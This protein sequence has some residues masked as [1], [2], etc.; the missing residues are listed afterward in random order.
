M[1]HNNSFIVAANNYFLIPHP[2]WLTQEPITVDTPDTYR[3]ILVE[4]VE[5]L[6]VKPIHQLAEFL[7][8]FSQRVSIPV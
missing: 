2:V 3:F 1:G 7:A 8:G 6:D 4:L 5:D